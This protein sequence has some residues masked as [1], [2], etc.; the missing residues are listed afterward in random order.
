[1]ALHLVGELSFRTL[2]EICDCDP[3]TARKRFLLALRRARAA[4]QNGG[5]GSGLGSPIQTPWA[6]QELQL[7]GSGA[8]RFSP[9]LELRG[10]DD[11]L[12]IGLAG[13]VVMTHWYGRVDAAA[14]DLLLRETRFVHHGGGGKFGYLAIVEPSCHP[15][16]IAERSKILELLRFFRNDLAAYAS[17][18][19]SNPFVYPIMSTL[20]VLAR[21][22]FPMRFRPDIESAAHW[23]YATLGEETGLPDEASL[24]QA[25]AALQSHWESRQV[26]LGERESRAV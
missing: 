1:L 8:F 23:L 2:A 22:P 5:R 6:A 4:A 15:P 14:L 24:I 9:H 11:G 3:K 26:A 19:R 16:G 12:A 20:A 25:A 21:I 10:F 17:V 13:R 7:A 18:Q